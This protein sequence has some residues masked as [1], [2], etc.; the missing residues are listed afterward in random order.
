[1]TMLRARETFFTGDH[2]KVTK[3]DIVDAKDPIVK[4]KERLFESL[5]VEQ[6]TAAPGELRTLP[7]KPKKK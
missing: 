4:G 2:R 5:G 7:K 1:M 6:A 3:G